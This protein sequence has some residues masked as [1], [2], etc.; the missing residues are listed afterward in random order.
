MRQLSI[1]SGLLFGAG[2]L[3]MNSYAVRE[4][5]AAL[6]LFSAGFAVLLLI[7]LICVL[8]PRAAQGGAMWLQIRAPQWN[9]AGR[10]WTLEFAH[11]LQGRHLWQRWAHRTP[12]PAGPS[13]DA[14]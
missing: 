3:G 6:I 13:T 5:F 4:L 14:D 2:L 8:V 7:T 1:F 12:T 9:R 10:D 11:L